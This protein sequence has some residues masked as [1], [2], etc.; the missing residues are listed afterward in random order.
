[1]NESVRE[2]LLFL[3]LVDSVFAKHRNIVLLDGR[4]K[5]RK[6]VHVVLA[7]PEKIARSKDLFDEE[8]KKSL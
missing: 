1:M 8:W 7:K 2:C 6:G 3:S 5:V 4:E